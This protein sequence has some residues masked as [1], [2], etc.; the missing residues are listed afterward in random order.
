MIGKR[1]VEQEGKNKEKER[2]EGD[3]NLTGLGEKR[4]L[5]LN[6]LLSSDQHIAFVYF[7]YQKPQLLDR[8]F[9]FSLYLVIILSYWSICKLPSTL[10]SHHGCLSY[11][12]SLS[13]PHT[14][15]LKSIHLLIITQVV[16]CISNCKQCFNI[17]EEITSF[18]VI[19]TFH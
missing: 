10:L 12:L 17:H 16:T 19:F 14:Y 11:W 5:L 2:D 1:K 9:S 4:I 7:I 13:P 6:S 3:L 18:F 8:I 15:R